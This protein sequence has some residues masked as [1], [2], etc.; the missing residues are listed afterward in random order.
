[1]T[2]AATH[3]CLSAPRYSSDKSAQAEPGAQHLAAVCMV[4]AVSGAGSTAKSNS[5]FLTNTFHKEYIQKLIEKFMSWARCSFA[6][7]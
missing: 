3:T 6:V 4:P 5:T 7:A 2:T 1:M